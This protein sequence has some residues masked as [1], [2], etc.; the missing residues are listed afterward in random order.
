[1]LHFSVLTAMQL[2]RFHKCFFCWLLEPFKHVWN[3]LNSDYCI[4]K[5]IILEVVI[6]STVNNLN[7]LR[8]S[9]DKMISVQLTLCLQCWSW[10]ERL[11]TS[12]TG[13]PWT[14]N[15]FYTK[16][17]KKKI[18]LKNF[19]VFYHVIKVPETSTREAGECYCLLYCIFIKN[20]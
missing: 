16:K 14:G 15:F 18:Y 11:K 2:R 4:F 12:L 19:C 13:S 1:M 6:L 10:C 20:E 7:H 5:L 17:E 9:L 3:M 8:K